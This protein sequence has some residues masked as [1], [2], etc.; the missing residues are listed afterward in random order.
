MFAPRKT[1]PMGNEYHLIC[2][3]LS[4]IMYAIELVEGKDE[5]P[6]KPCYETNNNR[7]TIGLLLCLTKLIIGSGM[8]AIL[9]SGLCFLQGLIEL[10]KK[11]IFASAL[12]KKQC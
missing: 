4:G 7:K 2:C 3:G 10:Q 6:Q 11:G 12:V 9:D 8:A 1:H 5:P